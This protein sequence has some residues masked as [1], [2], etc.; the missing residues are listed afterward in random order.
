[1]SV[2]DVT[3]IMDPDPGLGLA[4]RVVQDFIET[5]CPTGLTDEQVDVVMALHN[6]VRSCVTK[7][8]SLRDQRLLRQH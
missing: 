2:V 3:E 4:D 6:H 5:V 1:M 8:L 7:C